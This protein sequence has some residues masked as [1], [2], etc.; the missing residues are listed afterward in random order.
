MHA[1]LSKERSTLWWH[2]QHRGTMELSRCKLSDIRRLCPLCHVL[3]SPAKHSLPLHCF[4]SSSWSSRYARC[5]RCSISVPTSRRYSD[6]NDTKGVMPSKWTQFPNFGLEYPKGKDIYYLTDHSYGD[7]IL[8]S[9]SASWTRLSHI[10]QQFTNHT[11]TSSNNQP[12]QCLAPPRHSSSSQ[13]PR[14]SMP[15]TRHPSG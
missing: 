13:D 14:F 9:K 15:L 10:L 8:Q 1:C 7:T 3:V 5:S 12:T 6:D 4:V 11:N 2:R